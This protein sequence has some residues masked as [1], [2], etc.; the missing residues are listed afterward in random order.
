M[1]VAGDE[2][3]VSIAL[4][5][6]FPGELLADGD[7]EAFR[8]RPQPAAAPDQSDE[9]VVGQHAVAAVASEQNAGGANR[10]HLYG[11]PKKIG[12]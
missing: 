3:A 2:S 10:F 6:S 8:D 5:E 7:P 12:V 1:A 9:N 4:Q 11:V